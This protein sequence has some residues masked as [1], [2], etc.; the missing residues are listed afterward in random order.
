MN[1]IEI[2]KTLCEARGNSGDEAEA[3]LAAKKLLSP[4]GRVRIDNLGSVICEVAPEKNG[5]HVLLD[6]HLDQI[7]L[8]VNHI[9]ENGFVFAQNCGGIDRRSIW[10]TGVTV[11]GKDGDYA[12]VVCSVPKELQSDGKQENPK[13]SEFAVDIGFDKATAE[14]L[15][16]PGDRVILGGKWQDMGNGYVTSPALDDRSGCVCILEALELLKGKELPCGLTAV[17]SSREETGG[18]GAAATA[19]AIAPTEALEMD[20]SFGK[21]PDT[22]NIETKAMKKGPMIGFGPSL[23]KALSE[24]LVALAKKH[25]IPFQYEVMS[26]STG[27]NADDIAKSGCGV[28]CC[29]VSIPQ[30]YMHTVIEKM[31]VEDIQNTGRLIAAYVTE[32][33]EE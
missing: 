18:E 32:G 22:D 30:Q 29:T 33:G 13:P 21:T 26:G 20:V 2:L 1:T 3:A 11:V 8:I 14:R 6:A 17:F 31:A 19:A 24:R 25:D 28:R 10:G 7:A 16:R 4:Y 27:T 9:D 5:R 23:D 12:G 15:V